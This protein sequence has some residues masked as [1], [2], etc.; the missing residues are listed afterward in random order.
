ME[1][2]ADPASGEPSF[3]MMTATDTGLEVLMKLMY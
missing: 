3:A 2:K 1:R